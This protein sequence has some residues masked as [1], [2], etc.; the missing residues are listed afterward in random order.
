MNVVNFGK[1]LPAPGDIAGFTLMEVGLAITVG[2]VLVAAGSMAYM[3]AKDSAGDTAAR[4]RIA[5]LQT[6]IENK[7][8]TNGVFPSITEVQQLWLSSR[9]DAT[10]SP[11][12][13]DVY[14]GVPGW[15]ETGIE[16]MDLTGTPA[17]IS[18]M[19][20]QKDAVLYYYRLNRPGSP[21]PAPGWALWDVPTQNFVR[22][23]GYAVAINKN[24]RVFFFVQSGRL[25]R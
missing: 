16:G 17:S 25:A 21:A 4:Q 7:F 1:V 15:A 12:G 8:T 6:V 19:T 13:G 20:S 24:K 14:T 18:A 3:G 2:I 22:V 9:L 11:W 10:R 23:A 5:D